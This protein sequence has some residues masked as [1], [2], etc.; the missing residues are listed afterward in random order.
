MLGLGGALVS[1]LSS[2]PVE[3]VV[4]P[5]RNDTGVPG[6]D[7]LATSLSTVMIDGAVRLGSGRVVP[8]PA[9]RHGAGRR[10]TVKSRLILWD[11]APELAMSATDLDSG[12]VVWSGFAAGPVSVLA[13]NTIAKLVTLGPMLRR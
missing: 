13:R 12:S 10:L 8:G 5:V 1:R 2:H 4:E 3:L 9:V 7:P 6:M 11:G